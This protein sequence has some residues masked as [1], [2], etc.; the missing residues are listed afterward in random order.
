MF[1]GTYLSAELFLASGNPTKVEILNA[2]YFV[3]RHSHWNNPAVQREYRQ[4]F[5]TVIKDK[6]LIN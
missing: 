5:I 1:N 6:K 3:V 2:T 4:Y